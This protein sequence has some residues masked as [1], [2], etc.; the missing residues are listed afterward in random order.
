ML[1]LMICCAISQSSGD[2]FGEGFVA[3]VL[4]LLAWCDY[5]FDDVAVHHYRDVQVFAGR[6]LYCLH[7]DGSAVSQ[8]VVRHSRFK[9]LEVID[10]CRRGSYEGYAS[11]LLPVVSSSALPRTKQPGNAVH[12]NS[13]HREK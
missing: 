5:M 1:H 12:N 3:E 13:A 6:G 10:V 4:Q 2:L 9:V 11:S 7:W 8:Q